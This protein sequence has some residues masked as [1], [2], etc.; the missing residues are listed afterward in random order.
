MVT[1]MGIASRAFRNLSRRKIRAALVVVAL[2]FCMAILI[3][4]PSGIA[5]NQ[6]AT[7]NLT[8]GLGNTIAQTEATINQTLTQIDCSISSGFSGFGFRNTTIVAPPS[9]GDFGGMPS[10]TGT[11]DSGNFGGFGGGVTTGQFGGG[12]LGGGQSS[13]M[14]QTLYS[15]INSTLSGVAAVEP[16]LQVTEGPNET[17]TMMGR[18]FTRQITNYTIEGVPLTADL[19]N[20]YPILP[21]NITAGRNLEAGDSGVVLLS[22]NNSKTFKAGV[23]D[24][25]TILNETFKVVGIY[26]SSAVSN[27]QTL[28]MNLSDAQ[29]I[30]DNANYITSLTVFATDSDAVSSVSTAI[31]SLHPELT[32]TTAQERLSLLQQQESVYNSQLESAQS[33]MNQTQSQ[34]IEEII[35]AV[36]ATSVIVL[37][38]MLYTVRERTKEVGTLKAM[39]A[40]NSTVMSQFLLEG[41]MLSLAAGLVA[42]IIAVVATPYLSSIL[43]PAVG[44]TFGT[45]GGVVLAVNSSTAASSASAVTVSPEWMLIGFGVA[46]ALGAVGSLYPAWRAARTR[47]AEAMR[48]E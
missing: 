11:S 6:T 24:T 30:T 14:N 29:T 25:I 47:P 45:R 38:V 34:A 10:S 3:A 18:T 28:Y 16:V 22:E 20:N 27:A 17:M 2:G 48:Y 19:V 42:V 15:D 32:V 4:V 8:N 31:S 46:V 5:A 13:P 36:T 1:H 43:L 39:G 41:I 21:T 7:N 37:F 12:A 23:G 40:S 26:S 33:T 35:I 9:G 44:N